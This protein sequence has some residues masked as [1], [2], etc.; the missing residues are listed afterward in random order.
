M[1]LAW[2]ESK[3]WEG[4]PTQFLSLMLTTKILRLRRQEVGY[5]VIGIVDTNSSPDGIDYVIPGND[6]AIRSIKLF[7]SALADAAL[8]GKEKRDGVIRPDDF[9]EIDETLTPEK[10]NNED[11]VPERTEIEEPVAESGGIQTESKVDS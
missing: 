11:Q 1:R 4:C 6:D 3:I 2:E 7:V 5:P 8:S 9:V 10:L